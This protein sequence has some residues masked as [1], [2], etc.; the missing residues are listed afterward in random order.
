MLVVWEEEVWSDR[1][2]ELSSS[3]GNWIEGNDL[4]YLTLH[5]RIAHGALT[6]IISGSSAHA[7][8]CYLT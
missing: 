2:R 8:R 7:K 4:A 5:R 1:W 3:K 6:Q